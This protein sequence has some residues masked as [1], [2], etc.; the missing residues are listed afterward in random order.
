MDDQYKHN[1]GD[2]IENR[3]VWPS[4]GR[5]DLDALFTCQ[6]VNTKLT[7]PKEAVVVLDLIRKYER[8]FVFSLIISFLY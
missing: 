8:V 6:A 3:L 5:K 1:A 7:D 4:I 2:V